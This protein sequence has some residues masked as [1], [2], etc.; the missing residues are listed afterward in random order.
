M[1]NSTFSGPVRSQN[2]FQEL[3]D[4]VWTPVGGGGGGGG[5]TFIPYTPGTVIYTVT[6]LTNPG[7]SASFCWEF[8]NPP[9]TDTLAITTPV[10]PG[11]DGVVFVRTMIV[12][13]DTPSEF[14]DLNV[15]VVNDQ[16]SWSSTFTVTYVGNYTVMGSPYAIMVVDVVTYE[17]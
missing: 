3:V 9:G 5:V 6:G 2:G 8:H 15:L 12:P 11:T 17:V 1:A 7:D 16:Y 13:N 4:G 14:N 10:I